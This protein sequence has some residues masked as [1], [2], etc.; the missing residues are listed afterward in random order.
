MFNV[1][2]VDLAAKCAAAVG[3]SKLVYIADGS[4]LEDT[5]TGIYPYFLFVW[6]LYVRQTARSTYPPRSTLFGAEGEE[7]ERNGIDT[8]ALVWKDFKIVPCRLDDKVSL[9]VFC[10]TFLWDTCGVAWCIAE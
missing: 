6:L 7:R 1:N 3:A 2:S 8:D 5:I 10:L 4:Y 9:A